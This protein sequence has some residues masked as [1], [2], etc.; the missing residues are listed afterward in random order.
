MDAVLINSGDTVMTH[1]HLTG[2][3][4][5]GSDGEKKKTGTDLS[6]DR[7]IWGMVR[8]VHD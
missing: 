3:S 4:C 5:R 6:C 8:I 1:A 2:N 7:A